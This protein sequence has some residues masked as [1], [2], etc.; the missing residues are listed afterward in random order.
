MEMTAES[1][2]CVGFVGSPY[3]GLVTSASKWLPSSLVGV[4]AAAVSS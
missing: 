2:S 4:V 3:K 1:L